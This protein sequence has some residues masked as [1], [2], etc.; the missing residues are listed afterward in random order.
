MRVISQDKDIDIDYE[1]CT[2][3]VSE[4][5]DNDE[6]D[7]Y[8]DEDYDDEDDEDDD[9]IQNYLNALNVY[10]II[11]ITKDGHRFIM[12]KYSTKEKAKDALIGMSNN[13]TKYL[14]TDN[15]GY[16]TMTDGIDCEMDK[17]FNRFEIK[18]LKATSY[19]FPEDN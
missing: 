11:A 1:S 16:M 7:D 13:Y 15:N 18:E 4:D 14:I 17:P 10:F 9:S 6:D 12:A 19:I 5:Y 3:I 8:D 2:F